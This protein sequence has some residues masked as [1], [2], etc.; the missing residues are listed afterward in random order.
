[1]LA[2]LNREV[3]DVEVEV[4]FHRRA[5]RGRSAPATEVCRLV[6][7]RDA[8]TG[9]YHCFLTN[10]TPEQLRAADVA[11][12]YRA[13]WTVELLLKELKRLYPRD[14]ITSASPVV[15]EAL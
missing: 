10:L 3:L 4:T 13:R 7:I 8:E 2:T 12:V 11:A 6:G 5:Y 1:M 9:R 15:I 14:V